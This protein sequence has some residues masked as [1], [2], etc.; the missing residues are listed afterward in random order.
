M[1]EHNLRRGVEL[2]KMIA[3]NP[4]IRES[5]MNLA[6]RIITLI[7]DEGYKPESV[8]FL[9]ISPAGEPRKMTIV[10]DKAEY[11]DGAPIKEEPILPNS[12]SYRMV[13]FVDSLFK[14][15]LGKNP[16]L[17]GFIQVCPGLSTTIYCVSNYILE[18]W[19]Q[20]HHRDLAECVRWDSFDWWVT[21]DLMIQ[22]IING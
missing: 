9:S 11:H 7:H 6:K 1:F 5:I 8:E 20:Y 13:T 16:A 15:I 18:N 19:Y 12:S 4:K 17:A 10:L 2:H 22:G 14:A 21:K 3:N